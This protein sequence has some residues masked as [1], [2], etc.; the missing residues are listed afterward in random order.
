[1]MSLCKHESMDLHKPGH[2][3][4]GGVDCYNSVVRILVSKQ[5][6]PIKISGDGD[7]SVSTP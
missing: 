7:V 3:G 5:R 1:M 4:L 6:R 2:A